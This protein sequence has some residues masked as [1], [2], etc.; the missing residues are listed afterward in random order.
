MDKELEVKRLVEELE[1]AKVENK[2]QAGTVM[3]LK[4][5]WKRARHER[6]IFEAECK[7]QRT[8]ISELEV[9]RD[10]SIRRDSHAS[11]REVADRYK[12]VLASLD[13]RWANKKKYVAAVVQL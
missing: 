6:A 13:E 5:K 12:E 3:C 10:Q 11:H 2:R 7:S 8:R 9:E 4:N 1:A